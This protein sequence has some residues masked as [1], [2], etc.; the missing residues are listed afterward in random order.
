MHAVYK[1]IAQKSLLLTFFIISGCTGTLIYMHRTQTSTK[2]CMLPQRQQCTTK[3]SLFA[4]TLTVIASNTEVRIAVSF[5][6]SAIFKL[7][8]DSEN[9]C[10]K[11]IIVVSA[12]NCPT[13]VH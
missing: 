3:G 10:Q 1:T 11:K 12:V 8:Q 6:S 2:K 5:C 9:F 4:T 7:N 13:F